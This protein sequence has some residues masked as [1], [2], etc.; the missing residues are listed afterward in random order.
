MEPLLIQ[1]TGAQSTGKTTLASELV[2]VF[3]HNRIPVHLINE[4][5]R[6]FKRL[7]VINNLDVEADSIDQLVLNDELL[8]QYFMNY[9]TAFDKSVI[10]AERSFID[11]LAYGSNLQEKT[12]IHQFV[13]E[14]NRRVLHFLKRLR[15]VKT[16]YFPLDI[17]YENDGV[18]KEYSRVRVDES[19][20]GYLDSLGID[21]LT[22]T[23]IDIKQRVKQVLEYVGYSNL[24][25]TVR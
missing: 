2:Q 7:G 5:S 19:I 21:H 12:D 16:I 9:A 1:F 3:S 17:P 6:E 15:N 22:L 24:I 18:R 14:Q 10:L 8:L 23:S 25:N 4:I 20:K 13:L 11:C